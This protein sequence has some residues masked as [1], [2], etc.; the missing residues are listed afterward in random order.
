MPDIVGR[1]NTF[2][3]EGYFE[4]EPCRTGDWQRV[5]WQLVN[6]PEVRR[7]FTLLS[8]ENCAGGTRLLDVGCGRGLFLA[9]AQDLGWDAY[10]FDVTDANMAEIES[11]CGISIAVGESPLKQFDEGAFDALFCNHV[12]EHTQ[13]PVAFMEELKVLLKPGGTLFLGFPNENAMMH[14]YERTVKRLLGR[15][16]ITQQPLQLPYHLL[17]FTH[18]AFNCLVQVGGWEVCWSRKC[19]G[20]DVFVRDSYKKPRSLRGSFHD[21]VFFWMAILGDKVNKGRYFQVVL[22]EPIE[23]G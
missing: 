11:K 6:D 15:P 16:P 8:K 23:N 12:L 7:W 17:G 9:V 5:Y 13:H 4:H 14:T 10:G 1:L 3:N 2:Y 19:W 20:A 21:F 22:R 18:K